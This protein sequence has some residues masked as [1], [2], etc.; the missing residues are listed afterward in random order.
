MYHNKDISQSQHRDF[1]RDRKP[2]FWNYFCLIKWS[3][4]H[5][6]FTTVYCVLKNWFLQFFYLPSIPFI[7]TEFT[8][9]FSK[10]SANIQPVLLPV[11]PEPKSHCWSRW[12]AHRSCPGQLETQRKQAP[13]ALQQLGILSRHNTATNHPDCPQVCL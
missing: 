11:N 3:F 5:F 4:S 9:Q 10:H 13:W 1:H 2:E 6:N 8:L 7:S 12:G